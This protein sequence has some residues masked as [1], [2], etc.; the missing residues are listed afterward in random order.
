MKFITYIM[1]A[2]TYLMK[3]ITY[4]MKV[5]LSDEGYYVPDEVY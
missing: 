1:K 3:V 5:I 2:I 4:L